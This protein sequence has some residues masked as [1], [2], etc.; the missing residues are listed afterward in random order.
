MLL[1]GNTRFNKCFSF[2]YIF[3][4]LVG[5]IGS[6]ALKNRLTNCLT[7]LYSIIIQLA[8]IYRFVF[9]FFLEKYLSILK[10]M[11]VSYK[12]IYLN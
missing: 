3:T 10:D 8:I 9:S 4:N 12:L 7:I 2:L 1:F 6:Y 11:S 5:L